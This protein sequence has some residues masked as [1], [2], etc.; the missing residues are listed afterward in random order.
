MTLQ[1][2]AVA[3]D[4]QRGHRAPSPAP[5]AGDNR[6]FNVLND[7]AVPGTHGAL[8]SRGGCSPVTIVLSLLRQ[9]LPPDNRHGAA[10]AA[11]SRLGERGEERR[12]TSLLPAGIT[13]LAELSFWKPVGAPGIFAGLGAEQGKHRR[14]I[15]LDALCAQRAKPGCGLRA[16]SCWACLKS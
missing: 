14:G 5:T 1:G 3:G 12:N 10:R 8:T 4:T 13:L 16:I 6:D 7:T 15:F 11:R 2:T 9:L